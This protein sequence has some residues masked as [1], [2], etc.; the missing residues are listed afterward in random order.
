MSDPFEALLRLQ[1][2]LDESR[3]RDWF[4]VATARDRAFPPLNVFQQG[5]DYVVVAEVPG[6]RKED[7][8]LEV[9]R[10]ALR[11]SGSKPTLWGD[12]VSVH[13]KERLAGRFDR[14]IAFPVEIDPD[15]V[16]AE[17]REG[18]L[19]IFAPLAGREKTRSIE[20]R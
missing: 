2:S 16:K 14:A 15:G 9:R 8:Q 19:A 4:G 3:G 5:D 18:I 13:R 17:Y 20:I 6:V 10:N 1:R 7:L 12:D 11:L